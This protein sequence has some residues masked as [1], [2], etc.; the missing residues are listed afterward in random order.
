MYYNVIAVVGIL[1]DEKNAWCVGPIVSK[2]GHFIS[3]KNNA[4]IFCKIT[5]FFCLRNAFEN[6]IVL[7]DEHLQP[8]EIIRYESD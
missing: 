8:C 1:S 4:E 5:F 7:K 3:C 2:N 6:K